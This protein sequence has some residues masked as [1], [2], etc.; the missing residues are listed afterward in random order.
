[1]A[2]CT[3][4]DVRQI[5]V[6]VLQDTDIT[7]LIVD[8]DAEITRRGLTDLPAD[9]RKRVSMY[10][11]AEVIAAREPGQRSDQGAS[12]APGETS[13]GWRKKAEALI[14]AVQREEQD[15]WLRAFA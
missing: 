10:L 8:S 5:I 1:M 4:N 11:T 3:Y 2:N 14:L 15:D 7:A 13:E 6:T 9:I 12:S